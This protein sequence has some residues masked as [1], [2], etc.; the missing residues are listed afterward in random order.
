MTPAPGERLQRFAGD[1]VRFSIAGGE[2]RGPR[3]GWRAVLRTNIGRA[4]ALRREII[5]AH[6]HGLPSAEPSWRDIPMKEE[7]EGW[8]LELV[9][10]EPGSFKAKAYLVDERGWQRWPEGADIRIMVHPDRYRTANT[11]Y[12]AFTRLFGE[13]KTALHTKNDKLENVLTALDKQAYAVIPPSGKLRDLTKALPHIMDTLS[14][15]IL[16]LLPVNPTPTTYARFGRFGS[17]YAA[18]SLTSIDPALV[19]FDKRTTAIEQFRELTYATHLRGGRLFLDIAINHTGW[20]S[21]LQETHPEWFL[22]QADGTFASPGAWGVAWEDLVELQHLNVELW[23]ELA[24]TFL[25]W[26]RRGVDGFRC[27]AGYK[28]PVPAWQYIVAR[29][30]QEYPEAVFLLEGLGGAWETTE[31]LLTDGGMQWAY[32]ELFQNYSGQQVSGYLEHSIKQSQRVGLLVHYSETHDNNRL[33]AR[34]RAWSLLRN[35]L[36]ALASMSGAFGFTCGVEWLVPEKIDVHEMSGLGWDNPANLIPELARLNHVL[37]EHPCFFDGARLARLTPQGSPVLALLRESGEGK[38]EVLVLVNLDV[39]HQNSIRLDVMAAGQASRRPRSPAIQATASEASQPPTAT[40]AEPGPGGVPGL[41]RARSGLADWVDLLG[42]SAPAM[43]P[44]PGGGAII[45]LPP[46]AAYCLAPSLAPRG[47]AGNEYRRA[48]AQA[49]WAAA[50]LHAIMPAENISE[51]DWLSLAAEVERAPYDFLAACSEWASGSALSFSAA[52]EGGVAEKG[53]GL[54]PPPLAGEAFQRALRRVLDQE[55]FPRVVAWTLLDCR[56]VTLLAPGHWLLVQDTAPFRA[57]LRPV[58]GGLPRNVESVPVRG[59]HAACFAPL[60]EQP[61]GGL[62]GAGQTDAELR[63]E[64]YAD[65]EQHL[66]AIIRFLP[67]VPDLSRFSRRTPA[68]GLQPTD[69]VLLT[70]GRGGMARLCVDVGRINSK[71][72]CV[73]GANLHPSLPVDRHVLAK[74]IRV[75]VNADGFISPLDFSSLVEFESGPPAVWRFVAN[76]GDGRTVQIRMSAQMVEGRNTTVFQFSRPTAAEASGKQL[77]PQADVRLTVRVGIEDRSFHWETHRNGGAE[78]HFA[79]H[80]HTLPTGADGQTSNEAKV[81]FVFTPAPDRQLRVFSENGAYHPEPEWSQNIPHPVEQSRGQVGSGDAYSPGWFELPLEKGTSHTL[82]V[83]SEPSDARRPVGISGSDSSV[84]ADAEDAFGRQ[85]LTATRAFVVRRGEGK[86]V[87]AGYPWFLDWGRDSFICARG[88]L[89]AGLIEEVRELVATFARFEKDG[90]LPNTIFGE[91]ASN[92]DTSDAPLWFGLVCEELASISEERAGRLAPAKEGPGAPP[93]SFYD[94]RVDSSGRKL[95]DVLES[96]ARNYIKGTPNRIRMDPAS[97]LIWSPSHFTW[98]D[99]NFPACTPREG[100]PVELQALWIRLLRQLAHLAGG[101]DTAY[102]NGL[103]EQAL[104]S[105][106]SLFWRTELGYFADLLRAAPGQPANSATVDD[107]LRS[108]C[109]FPMSLGLVDGAPARRCVEAARRFLLVP[110]ALRS[111]A[112]LPVKVPLPNVDNQG[113]SLNN[114]SRPYWGRYEG[115]EDTRRKPAYHNGTAW[116]WSLPVFCEALTRAWSFAPEAVAAARAYL[117]SVA[118]LLP[119]GC[120]GQLPE[121]LDGDS[122]HTQRGCDAQAWSVTEALRVWRLLRTTKYAEYAKREESKGDPLGGTPVPPESL[123]LT[124]SSIRPPTPGG[125][126]WIQPA[127]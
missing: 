90:T 59:G 123:R 74:R 20:G 102:W 32:S 17:P 2:G 75:W 53:A 36:C 49:A 100:Y 27:D 89:A 106:R 31:A 73:L 67:R 108:N 109:L 65:R 62:S 38:D 1:R 118:S 94:T 5:L 120:I 98:M 79:Q 105:M 112:P 8:S 66:K 43:Q 12:C 39:E 30:Q 77:P 57:A 72:D 93:S 19:V 82:A 115:D 9:L 86:T 51:I 70:N 48:R 96:I 110:G 117:G 87:I 4:E 6:A 41:D 28:V 35:R 104:A 26:C 16:H 3:N 88:L 116:V 68:S 101:N 114:P 119:Q 13:N 47:L 25:T 58:G 45:T 29:V 24:E 37:T 103:A 55:G 92:R 22:R 85:L 124:T 54:T 63:L 84:D 34:G 18:L 83:T 69:L 15:R 21:V 99:T 52:A 40:A 64:R 111:L 107:A 33:A 11:L 60:L 7:G 127:G 71:Y 46:G 81:G 10:A 125:Q 121:V 76:A 14:C 56:R 42:Q 78:H 44:G 95:R 80:T 50:A 126:G 23:D 91:D 61:G 113:K 97:G 122:P